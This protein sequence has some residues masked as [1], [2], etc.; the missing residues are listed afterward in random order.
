MELSLIWL[1]DSQ[2]ICNGRPSLILFMQEFGF[3]STFQNKFCV[4]ANEEFQN[5]RKRNN[6]KNGGKK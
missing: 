1:K 3:Y 5:E 6:F 4:C 2:A